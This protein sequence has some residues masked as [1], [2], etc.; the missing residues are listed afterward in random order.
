MDTANDEESKLGDF[1]EHDNDD[2]QDYNPFSAQCPLK[3]LCKA[4]T[5]RH[6]MRY[7]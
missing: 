4:G 5:V 6:S 2:S 3:A 1:K 7:S